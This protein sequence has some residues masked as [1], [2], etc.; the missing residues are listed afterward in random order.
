MA[1]NILQNEVLTNFI[2]PFL[3]I[4]FIVFA[5]LQKTKILGDGKKQLD[6]LVAF[7]IGLIF[8]GAVSPKLIVEDLIL[9][10]SVAIV[11]VFVILIIWGF[12]TGQDAKFEGKAIKI[13]AGIVILIAVVIALLLSVDSFENIFG[14]LFESDWSEDVWTNIIFVVILAVALAAVLLGTKK[15]GSS[16]GK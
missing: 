9:F 5:I 3:L 10:L 12:I 8:V 14:F 2:Y 16:G 13:I 4:F 1:E 7:V 11:M 15:S 6:A